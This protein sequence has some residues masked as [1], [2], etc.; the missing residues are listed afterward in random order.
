MTVIYWFNH[1]IYNCIC[2]PILLYGCE[3]L[4]LSPNNFKQLNSLQGTILK[5]VCGLGKRSHHSN[6]LKAASI[7]TIESQLAY[8]TISLFSRIFKVDSPLK[9]LNLYF[10]SKYIADNTLIKGTLIHRLVKLGFSPIKAA[11]NY[12][13]YKPICD[14]NDGVIDSVRSLIFNENFIHPLSNEHI[15]IKLLT[16]FF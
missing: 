9:N 7:D 10:M 15:L 16:R 4:S 12:V 13:P 8:H 6:L 3:T 14:T 11:F 1:F 5:S 2:I